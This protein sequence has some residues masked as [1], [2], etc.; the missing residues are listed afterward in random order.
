MQTY[1]LVF[2]YSILRLRGQAKEAETILRSTLSVAR[3]T[4]GDFDSLTATT[5]NNLGFL[6][7][8]SGTDRQD[9]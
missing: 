5:L 4:H 8:S 7:K 6:L 1:S 3:E 9:Y 2:A